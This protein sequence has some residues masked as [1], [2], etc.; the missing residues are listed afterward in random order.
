MSQSAEDRIAR[1]YQ[2]KAMHFEHWEK[3]KDLIDQLID[4]SLNLRQSGHPGGSRS[5]VHALVVV[6]LSGVMRWDIRHPEKRFADRFILVGGHTV[7]LVYATLA[8][9]NEAMRI[10]YQ[11]SGDKRYY[12]ENPPKGAVF[13]EDLLDL[14]HNGGLPGHAEMAGKT[15]F[16][17]FNTGPSGHGSPA[18]AGQAL[19]LKLAGAEQVRVFAF[20]GD[21]GHTPGANHETKNS[22]WGLGLSNLYYVLDW[23]DFGIDNH[24]ISSVVHG[25]PRDWFEPYGWRVTGTEQGN[26]WDPVTRAILEMVYGSNPDGVPSICW[27]KTRKGRGYGVYDNK[28]HGVPHAPMNSP[29]FWE[30]K[31]PFA[32]KYCVQFEGFGQPAPAT[33]EAQRAQTATNIAKVVEVLRNDR[34]LVDY[35][36]DTLVRL[37]D[38]VPEDIPTFRFST[39]ANPLNDQRLYDFEHYPPQMFVPPG[40]VI[41]NRAALAKF[42]AWVNAF[43]HRNYSRPLF[44]VCSADLAESTNIAGFAKEWEDFPG[45]GVYHRHRNTQGALLPQEITE[46][47]NA[48]IMAGMTTVNFAN[49]PYREFNGFL[50]ACSTYGSFAYL[51]YGPMRLFSQLAQD[52]DLKVG[53]VIWVAGH[54]GPETADDSRTHFG[55]FSPGTTQLFPEGQIIN[56]HPWEHNEVPVVLGAALRLD[57]HIIALHLTRPPITVP[58]RQALGMDSHFTAARGAYLIRPFK[59]G[60]RPMGTVLVQGT[61]T[62]ANIVKVLPELDREGLNVKIVAAISPE[63]FALQPQ[64]YRDRVLPWHEWLDSMTIT[65]GARRLMH[66]W[67]CHKVAEEYS[68]SSDWDNRWRTGGTVEELTEEA[69]LSPEWILKG[70]ERFVRDRE[71]RL[72]RLKE[73]SFSS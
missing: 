68:L 52:C 30:T 65:N 1:L 29:L 56:L 64:A 21:G 41:A 55:I 20:E 16:L 19:A 40:T 14:R 37:G 72:Q 18:A 25:T 50:G 10:K 27:V 2:E 43:S 44:I 22:A 51:K 69:H 61:S 57:A 71:K 6:L 48:G 62:T 60:R 24:P 73:A 13:P 23:N 67:L 7:P 5:K 28:S 42:G 15:L 53:K 36:A 26:E 66:D 47:A 58:D 38:Q 63:L 39:R 35:L 31:R 46:F 9:L 70:I 12:V 32:E 54:S 45:Y 11:E 8:V 3:V 59:A 33:P 49:D 34:A 17:K 4:L